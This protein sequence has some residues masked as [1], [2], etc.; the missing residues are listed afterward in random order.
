MGDVGHLQPDVGRQRTL[1]DLRLHEHETTEDAPAIGDVT[2]DLKVDT[3]DLI[4]RSRRQNA[5]DGLARIVLLGME[6]RSSHQ[7][8]AIEQFP[9]GADLGS[10]V[11]LG[12]KDHAARHGST[13]IRR[14][15]VEL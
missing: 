15:A 8:V 6:Q 3:L 2:A 4:G 11:A 1:Q 10:L 9:L 5:V 7:E 14:G 13:V 12:P